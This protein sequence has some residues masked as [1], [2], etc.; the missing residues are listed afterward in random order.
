MNNN[1]DIVKEKI[2]E[3][4]YNKALSFLLKIKKTKKNLMEYYFYLGKIFF[5]KNKFFSSQKFFK[6]V[7]SN[8]FQNN[9]ISLYSLI[10]LLNIYIFN[11]KYKFALELF[12]KF[13]R[14]DKK[15]YETISSN[16]VPLFKKE[17]NNNLIFV[18]E[19]LLGY[20]KYNIFFS[21]K[22]KKI[23]EKQISIYLTNLLLSLKDI[24]K[25]LMI[26]KKYAKYIK[27]E[28]KE[29]IS[30]KIS[31]VV[32]ENI[33]KSSEKAKEEGYEWEE[34][35]E[36][37]KAYKNKE[38]YIRD[39]DRE[40]VLN[41]ISDTVSEKIIREIQE[42]KGKEIEKGRIF[43]IAEIVEKYEKKKKYLREAED[44]KI[45]NNIGELVENYLLEECDINKAWKRILLKEYRRYN[46][47]IRVERKEEIENKI[48]QV[49]SE[50]IIKSSEKAKEED[51][52]WGEIEEIIK[53]YKNK[54]RY[55]KAGDREKVL[56]SISDTVSEKIIR[57]I[58]EEKGKEIE[59]GRIFEIAEIVEKYERK[60]KYIREAEDKKILNNIGELIE[61]YLLVK[62]ENKVE[63]QVII[64][65]YSGYIREGK[66]EEISDKISQVVSEDII[67]SSEKAK[68]EGCEWEEIEEII[69]AYKNK[70]R[71]IRDGDREK[72]LNNISDTVSEKIIRDIQE[73][74]GKKIEEER[75]AEIIQ[76]YE[77]KNRYIINIEDKKR[78]LY[79][80]KD[81]VREK[82]IKE[83]RQAKENGIDEYKITRIIEEYSRNKKYIEKQNID[84]FR[85]LICENILNFMDDLNFN[86]NYSK[87]IE[88]YNL[89][90]RFFIKKQ[91][92]LYNKLL[93][94]YEIATGKLVLKSKPRKL[95]FELTNSCNLNCIMCYQQKN[96]IY[97]ISKNVFHFLDYLLPYLEL[98]MWQGG[99]IL[100]IKYFKSL[101]LKAC[102][103]K[104]INNIITT[105]FQI[106]DDDMM[107][108]IAKNNVH[109]IISIDGATKQ[110]YEKIRIGGSFDKL[111]YN[112]DKF[113]LYKK[114]FFSTKTL[115][116]NFVI[117][118]QNYKEIIDIIYFAKEHCFDVVTFLNCYT[119]KT[120][121]KMNN[122][123]VQEALSLL[124]KAK[125]IAKKFNIEILDLYS[126]KHVIQNE[127]NDIFCYKKN[128]KNLNV[129]CDNS[130]K[131][132]ISCFLPWNALC[133][134]K[135]NSFSP[136]CSC[137][138]GSH[139]IRQYNSFNNL[140]NSNY[141]QKIRKNVMK[142]KC[143]ACILLEEQIKRI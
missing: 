75:I 116:L 77:K 20:E 65:R 76:K 137:S 13:G 4:D 22:E 104:R 33:I 84:L 102:S 79:Y 128:N 49:V 29:E 60:K 17:F 132:N 117:L 28:E 98:I 68:E 21:D 44:K 1:F 83:I 38:R 136:D 92:Y 48:S 85:N 87:T 135:D 10:Y 114:E 91:K 37:I 113:T 59:E 12:D 90:N 8:N 51:C 139:K 127:D 7:I 131:R 54:E 3:Q 32:S 36:I 30:D 88:I 96:I 40:K 143:H 15:Y 19:N 108:I 133:F 56:N 78:V 11:K 42:E 2:I 74:K 27:K 110:M 58:Q 46:V 25:I 115:Q 103:N 16:V 55:I 57:E 67:K 62:C 81:I 109:L 6:K 123:E 47:Y 93:N 72:V 95:L 41:S 14:F 121:V 50:D 80:I 18:D 94:E 9:N 100:Y 129:N 71:Y 124:N 31:Q 45:L 5:Y 63:K 118:K 39:G 134:Y 82:I 142:I 141:M 107:K 122:F 34:I 52:K 97:N 101:L 24:N 66:K 125:Q 61:N 138:I 106:V 35:E 126:N 112:I 53:A 26:I 130:T 70:E 105:N 69:K 99:E 23:I 64:K 43:E 89:Y 111:I 73:E 140:W 119:D 120:F 86:S